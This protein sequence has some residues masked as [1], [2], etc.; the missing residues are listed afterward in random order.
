MCNMAQAIGKIDLW[1]EKIT[2]SAISTN[3]SIIH[4]AIRWVEDKQNE[5]V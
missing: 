5:G 2:I 3:T 4:L 1:L